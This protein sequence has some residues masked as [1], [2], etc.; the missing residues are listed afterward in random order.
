MASMLLQDFVHRRRRSPSCSHSHLVDCVRL[1][2]LRA[3][4]HGSRFQRRHCSDCRLGVE[5]HREPRCRVAGFRHATHHHC[6][7]LGC[8]AHH[9][10][11]GSDLPAEAMNRL[12]GVA[13]LLSLVATAIGVWFFF[14]EHNFADRFDNALAR[15]LQW[16]GVAIALLGVACF[17]VGIVIGYSDED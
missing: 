6:R 1:L 11:T 7:L 12:G 4:V 5:G 3:V 14:K 10:A 9:V 13:A 17:L 2:C 8:H 16:V 15:Q